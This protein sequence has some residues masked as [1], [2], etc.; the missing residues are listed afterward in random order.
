MVLTRGL[1]I[2][3]FYPPHCGHEYLIRRA[4][5]HV[6][7]LHVMVF[8]RADET[9]SGAQRG[10]WLRDY[11]QREYTQREL[12]PSVQVHVQF[13]EHR[14]PYNPQD[15]V[16]WQAW[17]DEIGRVYKGKFDFVFSSETYGDELARR[18]GAE[19]VM[20]DRLREVVPIS[21]TM[22]RADPRAC[23]EYISTPVRLYYAALSIV[24]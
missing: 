19:H 24:R 21:G 7:E 16:G 9:I 15:E 14:D 23:W 11:T 6:T 4:R 1:V 13:A 10:Q 8:Y 5:E 17:I 18:L 2:G 12:I 20:I 3:K 22:V